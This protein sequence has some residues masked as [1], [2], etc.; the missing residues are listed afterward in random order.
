MKN[1]YIY[2]GIA[3]IAIA[4]IA[5]LAISGFLQQ[6]F[7]SGQQGQSVAGEGGVFEIKSGSTVL[8]YVI[9]NPNYS[10]STI[11][12]RSAAGDISLPITGRVSVMTFQYV[13][14][15]DF[16][17]WETY[18]V[19]YLMNKTLSSGLAGDVVFVT[20]DVDPWRTTY[21]DVT[22]YQNSRA[23][24]LLKNVTWIWVLD[25]V[26]KMAKVWENFRIFVARD[27]NTGLITHSVG[28]YIFNKEGRL[29]YIIQPTKEG[30]SRLEDLSKGIWDI[31]Y[32]VAKS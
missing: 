3:F 4:A 26:D 25:D 6:A 31:L 2:V 18:V 14:C 10:I 1:L 29:I 15:P 19:V 23:G 7:S 28:F 27:P 9:R 11:D 32:R 5:I 20:I 16:C 30:W 22:S 8:A 21:E 12:V 13:R 17:H 24:K